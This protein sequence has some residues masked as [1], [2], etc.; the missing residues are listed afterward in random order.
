MTVPATAAAMITIQIGALDS[1]TAYPTRTSSRL[2]IAT[3]TM[4]TT[5]AAMNSQRKS[6]AA[7]R[8]CTAPACSAMSSLISYLRMRLSRQWYPTLSTLNRGFGVVSALDCCALDLPRPMGQCV[9]VGAGPNGV[10]NASTTR[11][12]MARLA[13]VVL[14][15]LAMVSC[16]SSRGGLS[17]DSTTST[18]AASGVVTTSTT[19]TSSGW[20]AYLYEVLDVV[21]ANAYFANKVDFTAWHQRIAERASGPPIS[22]YDMLQLAGQ[23]LVDLGDGHST[24]LS[25]GEYA[26]LN[27]TMDDSTLNTTP[28]SGKVLAGGIGYLTIPAVIAGAGSGAYDSYVTA[29]HQLLQQE[30]CGWIIDLRGNSGGSVPPMMAAVAPLLGPGTFLGYTDRDRA[31]FGYRTSDSTVTTVAD[32][33]LDPNPTP[34]GVSA[35]QLNTAPVAILTDGQTASAAEGVVVAFIGRGLTRSFGAATQGVPTGNS[36]IPLS[37]GSAL[38][39]TTAV[40]IDRRGGTHEGPVAPDVAVAADTTGTDDASV[41]AATAWLSQQSACRNQP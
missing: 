6:W 29:A 36:A 37:D 26:Q 34:T 22:Y 25:P 38:N 10:S 17:V 32:T 9:L 39:L 24:R 3:T 15:S 20:V 12:L 19:F 31:V 35:T 16:S 1:P 27:T 33:H 7:S 21:D 14:L 23:I 41:T 8:L 28:P 18:A 5:I 11:A 13:I 2:S 30:A 4:A 40:T